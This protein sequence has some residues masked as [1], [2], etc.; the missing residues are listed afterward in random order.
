[1]T[2]DAVALH[3]EVAAKFRSVTL[4]N[5]DEDQKF[6]QRKVMATARALVFTVVLVNGPASRAVGYNANDLVLVTLN[7]SLGL[8]VER[9]IRDSEFGS[10]ER[11]RTQGKSQ[12]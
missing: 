10:T 9:N 6:V 7:N 1:M 8:I 5:F 12:R 3:L 2:A 11:P 4:L